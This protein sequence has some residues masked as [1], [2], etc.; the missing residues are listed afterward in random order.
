MS[1]IYDA[2][3][4]IQNQ[5]ASVSLDVLKRESSSRK[6]VFWLVLFAII[7]SSAGTAAV[8]YGIV[9][10]KGGNEGIQTVSAEKGLPACIA[11]E[12]ATQQDVSGHRDKDVPGV[13][14]HDAGTGP[15]K[16][17]TYLTRGGKYYE[18]GEYDKA[19]NVYREALKFYGNDAKVLNNIGSVL[20]AK[21]E[22]K[23]ALTYFIQSSRANKGF[24]EPVYNMACAYAKMDDQSKAISELKKAYRLNPDV[25]LWAVQD[26]DFDSLRG[27]REFDTIVHAQ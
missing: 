20:L 19:M 9:A 7:L 15:E 16:V 22:L 3:Q 1:S 24:V 8:F 18:S 23:E 6:K 27:N 25:R 12:P 21:G 13:L 2:L 4:R 10:L 17:E 11:D 26:P 14:R 5:K